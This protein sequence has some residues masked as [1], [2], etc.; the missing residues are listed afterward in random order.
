MS[1][2]WARSAVNETWLM[3]RSNGLAP[4]ANELSNGMTIQFTS[5][6]A[7]PS[8]SARAYANALSKPLPSVGSPSSHG[9]VAPPS[10]MSK[11]GGNAGLSVPIWSLP[12]VGSFRPS[13]EHG[14]ADALGARLAEVP[15]DVE[16]AAA[17]AAGLLGA[18][19]APL[20]Q[21]AR[22]VASR[23]VVTENT[24]RM[25]GNLV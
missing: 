9:G 14:L 22:T 13:F 7:K 1:T 17:E 18:V 23:T 12:A 5:S 4:G 25:S 6:L 20:V 16:C 11:Y 3:S 2:D 15:A 8:L 19:V 21:A 24:R 10:G